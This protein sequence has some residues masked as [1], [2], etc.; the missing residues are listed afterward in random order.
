MLWIDSFLRKT[1]CPFSS[2]IWLQFFLSE[3]K[4]FSIFMLHRRLIFFVGTSC[5]AISS[6]LAYES[7]RG[8]LMQDFDRMTD[9]EFFLIIFGFCFTRFV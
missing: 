5:M 3:K 1:F 4:S 6:A 8:L 7:G 2:L 9:L